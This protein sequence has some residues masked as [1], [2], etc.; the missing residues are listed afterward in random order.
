MTFDFKSKKKNII[1]WAFQNVHQ[2]QTGYDLWREIV[3][4]YI[5]PKFFEVFLANLNGSG[6]GSS[7]AKSGGQLCLL[8]INKHNRNIE[9]S[10]I[11]LL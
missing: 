7:S 11:S 1:A 10:L 8:Q 4:V 9:I 6:S 2:N 3:L 5:T